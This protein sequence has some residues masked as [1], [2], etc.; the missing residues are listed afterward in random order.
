M[1]S[2]FSTVAFF[3]ALWLGFMNLLVS[4][5]PLPIVLPPS[6]GVT[7]F[8]DVVAREY[9]VDT[10]KRDITIT[11]EIA[12]VD[13]II[14]REPVASPEPAPDEEVDVEARICRFGCL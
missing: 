6:E 4:A 14:K 3:L 9:G 12:E 1:F 2:R 13:E 7:L 8:K 10:V 11:P 5:S